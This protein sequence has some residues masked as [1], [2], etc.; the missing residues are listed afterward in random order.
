MEKIEKEIKKLQEGQISLKKTVDKLQKQTPAIINTPIKE[1][2]RYPGG[3]IVDTFWCYFLLGSNK[4]YDISTIITFDEVIKHISN[5][6]TKYDG[7]SVSVNVAPNNTIVFKDY[8]EMCYRVEAINYPRFPKTERQIAKF[9]LTLMEYLMINLDQQRITLVTSD[10]SIM[11]ENT[12][13]MDKQAVEERPKK[14]KILY[15]QGYQDVTTQPLVEKMKE[16]NFEVI[17][18]KLD[19]DKGPLWNELTKLIEKEYPDVIIG[20]S[21]GGYMAYYLSQA[22]HLPTLLLAPAFF[23]PD[24]SKLQPIPEDIKILPNEP[25]DKV[26]LIGLND[27]DLNVTETKE[28]LADKVEHIGIEDMGHQVAL[29]IFTKYLTYFFQLL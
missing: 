23:P 19:Y 7:E 14:R 28:F 29:P 20:H 17:A 13:L 16:L 11:L 1:T 6:Q 4:G 5:F 9:M 25:K 18:P 10:K 3:K 12:A 26:A 27:E 21:L 22:F 24:W 8:K 15:L 2:V